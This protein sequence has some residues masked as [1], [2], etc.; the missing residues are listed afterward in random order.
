MWLG[1]GQFVEG[2][3]H[4][5]E[6]SPQLAKL[7]GHFFLTLYAR[8]GDRFAKPFKIERFERSEDRRERGRTLRYDALFDPPID[9]GRP[10]VF[11][12]HGITNSRC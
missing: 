6:R 1:C 7:S 11:I 10:I 4:I 8:I 2:G 9:V 5:V 12:S 3:L